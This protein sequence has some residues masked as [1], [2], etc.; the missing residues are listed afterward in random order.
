MRLQ[1]IRD[2]T[3]GRPPGAPAPTHGANGNK[4]RKADDL[5]DDDSRK[6]TRATN[7]VPDQ[8]S[9]T[10]EVEDVPVET[11]DLE[12]GPKEPLLSPPPAQPASLPTSFTTPTAPPPIIDEDEWAAFERDV[13]TPP[14]ESKISA[15]TAEATIVAAPMTAAEIAAQSRLEASTQT[16]ERR[17]VEME[18]EKEDAARRVEE[19]FDEMAVLEERVRRLREKRE[20]LRR[21][22]DGD[23]DKVKDDGGGVDDQT[24][25]NNDGDDDDDTEDYDWDDWG[26]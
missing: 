10:A 23:A 24:W 2:N 6:R 8:N 1:R 17:E 14:P 3:L 21:V 13:A 16:K 26:R 5:E 19:E 12:A 4:K 11:S 20:E 22:R 15:L 9:D 18:G 7:G 25:L